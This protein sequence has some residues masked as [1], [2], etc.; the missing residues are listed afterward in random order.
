MATIPG[1]HRKGEVVLGVQT[2][3]P[4]L[5]PLVHNAQVRGGSQMGRREMPP[6]ALDCGPVPRAPGTALT[7]LQAFLPH[8]ANSP[9]HHGSSS[10]SLKKGHLQYKHQRNISCQRS[11]RQRL[12]LLLKGLVG[13]PRSK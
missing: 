5:S 10:R 1:S 8:E 6:P 3:S 11:C 12:G 7:Q 2:L 4:T 13:V 9:I